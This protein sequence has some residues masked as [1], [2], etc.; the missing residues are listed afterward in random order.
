MRSLT[1]HLV[2]ALLLLCAGGAALLGAYLYIAGESA[3]AA[4]LA[5]VLSERSAA[6]EHAASLATA[7]AELGDDE[8]LIENYFISEQNIVP[9]LTTLQL[10]G[11]GF[12]AQVT[13]NSV[14]SDKSGK[15]LQVA[16]GVSGPF[17]AIARTVG[18]IEYA[19]YAITLSSFSVNNTG[20]TWNA[21]LTLLA[22]QIRASSSTPTTPGAA[23]SVV[24]PV[25][26]V[27][28]V[29]PTQTSTTSGSTFKAQTVP[30][31]P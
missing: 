20:K 5:T 18:G 26:P 19:P 4:S 12:G 14:G 13:V 16:L 17:E 31:L 2:L 22:A 7:R 24:T 8:N 15:N 9:F 30:K 11:S 21:T 10:I 1:F 27:A 6:S 23:D 28:P 3:T 29:I 25:T